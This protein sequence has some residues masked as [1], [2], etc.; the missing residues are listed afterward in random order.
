[1]EETVKRVKRINHSIVRYPGGL[2]AD[3]DHWETVMQNKDW[4]ID[5]DE[6]LEWTKKTGTSPMFTVNF[7]T[8]TVEEA[9]R[10]VKHT[11]IDKK[12]NVKYWEVGNELYGDWHAN[13]PQY[14]KDGGTIYGK[15]AREFI[16]AMKK[17]DPT[18]KVAVVCVLEGPWND[19]VLKETADIADGIIV[20]H[21]PQ[22]H[23]EENDYALLSSP[24]SLE[25][26]F[27]R[28]NTTVAK[29][30]GGKKLGIWLTEWNS[31]DFMPSLQVSSFVNAIFV[32]D[33][34][35]M[36]AKVGAESA[37]YWDIHNSVEPEGG[38]YGYLS[39]ASDEQIGPNVPRPSYWAFQM[40]S[41]ALR[42]QLVEASSGEDNLTTYLATKGNRKSLVVINKSALTSFN[43]KLAIPG[44]SGKAKVETLAAPG[45]AAGT[46][47][48][49]NAPDSKSMDIK[50][51]QS[52]NFPSNSITTITIE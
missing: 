37:Q 15:R 51:G 7:G 29:Y 14:G 2:R 16:I 43:A 28:L 26:I 12:A 40:V 36:L 41:D 49:M 48:K 32:A 8:G 38:D 46:L 22:H 30:S 1:L 45:Q 31:V 6:F 19:K 13:Y 47:I 10:W 50:E 21:Y 3:E 39:R 23:G 17:V 4:M 24:Q 25:G 20:H 9:A 34:L 11:N 18:I 35:S 42:G 44:F 5:T 27:A 52:Y 33:Y